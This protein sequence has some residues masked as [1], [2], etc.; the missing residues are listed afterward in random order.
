MIL[1]NIRGGKVIKDLVI[2]LFDY[3]LILVQNYCKKYQPKI[4]M[5]EAIEDKQYSHKAIQKMFHQAFEK[6]KIQN[7]TSVYS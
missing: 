2:I 5:F 7:M 6:T 1:I 4:W 3:L